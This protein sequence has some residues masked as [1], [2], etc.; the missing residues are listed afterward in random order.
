MDLTGFELCNASLLD[1]STAA[2]EAMTMMHGEAK[3]K[4]SKFFVDRNVHPQTIAV[5]QT[6]AEGFGI[7]V[8]VGDYQSV[9]LPKDEFSGVL[10]Q[11]VTP[12]PPPAACA[13]LLL[14]DREGGPNDRTHPLSRPS[15]ARP[16]P[17]P[18]CAPLPPLPFC[19]LDVHIPPLPLLLPAHPLRS[20]ALRPS[21]ARANHRLSP[22][23]PR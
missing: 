7:E 8:V 14:R 13:A 6:R 21:D 18:P 11:C 17:G 10:V 15:R 4:K 3:G 19:S 5:M 16:P 2:A 9:E 22:R 23:S 1:E 20:L 12:P